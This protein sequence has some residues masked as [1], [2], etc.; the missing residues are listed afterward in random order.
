[1]G[2]TIIRDFLARHQASWKQKMGV[3]LSSSFLILIAAFCVSTKGVP[4]ALMQGAANT[5]SLVVEV[6]GQYSTTPEDALITITFFKNG[7][8]EVLGGKLTTACEGVTAPNKAGE[9]SQM[10]VPRQPGGGAYHCTYADE[11]GYKT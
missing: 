10:S 6:T 11:K 1:M 8:A 4:V 7:H 2:T 9:R 3:L 5:L